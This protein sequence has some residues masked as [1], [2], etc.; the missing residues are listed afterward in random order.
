LSSGH[1]AITEV[2]INMFRQ[3]L[4]TEPN[5]KLYEELKNLKGKY[6]T[7]KTSNVSCEEIVNGKF[8]FMIFS[9]SFLFTNNLLRFNLRRQ[10]IM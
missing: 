3:Y 1:G 2:F 10:R 5:K 7:L 9:Y 8:S 4:A 6:P